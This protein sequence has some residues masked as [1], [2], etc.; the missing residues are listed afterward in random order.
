MCL[1]FFLSLGLWTRGAPPARCRAP[2]RFGGAGDTKLHH[3]GNCRQA[4]KTSHHDGSI[5]KPQCKC[6]GKY[7]VFAVLPHHWARF[8][9]TTWHQVTATRKASLNVLSLSL[10]FSVFLLPS[11]LR[12]LRVPSA[13]R[14]PPVFV[15]FWRQFGQRRGQLHSI[16]LSLSPSLCLSFSLSHCLA[17]TL[18]FVLR[19][20]L[21]TLPGNQ[22]ALPGAQSRTCCGTSGISKNPKP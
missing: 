22:P 21:G 5:S 19:S 11:G 17:C 12:G 4:K 1:L 20:L 3:R 8:L 9:W 2:N 6:S 13:L 10:S 18:L 7:M 14:E 16:S 15:G